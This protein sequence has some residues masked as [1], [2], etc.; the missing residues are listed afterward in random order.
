MDF[1]SSSA[2]Q[3]MMKSITKKSGQAFYNMNKERLK[4]L[5]FPLPPLE[6][7]QRIVDKINS[8]EPLIQEYDKYLSFTVVML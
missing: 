8:F 1:M 4:D 2:F 7:Q 5:Y 3:E 6:E